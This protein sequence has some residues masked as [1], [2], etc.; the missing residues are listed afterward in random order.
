MNDTYQ[1]DLVSKL[2][3]IRYG[4]TEEELR[5]ANIIKADIESFGGKAE[6]MGFKIPAYKANKTINAKKD[7]SLLRLTPSIWS[8]IYNRKFLSTNNIKFLPTPGASYQ[9]TSFTF[10]AFISVGVNATIA[11]N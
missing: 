6:I 9:D 1:Y 2:N 4:G 11:V 5:A 10:K 7:K 8:A 3:F